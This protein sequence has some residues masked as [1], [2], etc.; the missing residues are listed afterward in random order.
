MAR[1]VLGAGEQQQL[2]LAMRVAPVVV[3]QAERDLL[4][5]GVVAVLEGGTVFLAEQLAIDENKF[6]EELLGSVQEAR[7]LAVEAAYPAPDVTEL[8]IQKAFREAKAVGLEAGVVSKDLIE[9]ML[10]KAGAEARALQGAA[11]A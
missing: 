10:G 6:M 4:V 8:L 3:Q 11:H 2:A 9:E 5:V 1:R 7:N